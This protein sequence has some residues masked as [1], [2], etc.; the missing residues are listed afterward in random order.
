MKLEIQEK[1][2][3]VIKVLIFFFVFC[4]FICIATFIQNYN[5]CPKLDYEVKIIDFMNLLATASIGLAIPFFI[6][7]WVDNN[8]TIKLLL[9]EECKETLVEV[10]KLHLLISGFQLGTTITIEQQNGIMFLLETSEKKLDNLI[11]LLSDA[12]L[13]QNIYNSTNFKNTFLKYWED[14]T[15]EG[16]MSENYIFDDSFKSLI[17]ISYYDLEREIKHFIIKISVS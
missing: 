4:F 13:S 11:F 17:T 7:K 6:S 10:Q 15:G 2:M 16:L 5:L 3:K 9:I 12:K 14:L 1:R 8:K